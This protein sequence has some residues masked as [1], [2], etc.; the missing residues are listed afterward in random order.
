[1]VNY[2]VH[3][4]AVEPE[5]PVHQQPGS[6]AKAATLRKHI[7]PTLPLAQAGLVFVQMP[8]PGVLLY[9]SSDTCHSLS[10]WFFALTAHMG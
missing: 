6:L 10:I 5:D 4:E 2:Q 8:S 3:P 1:M 7:T 9:Q